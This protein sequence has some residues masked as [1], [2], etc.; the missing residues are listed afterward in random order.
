[1]GKGMRG[2]SFCTSQ[3]AS[4]ELYPCIV[5]VAAPHHYVLQ[6]QAALRSWALDPKLALQ[7]ESKGMAILQT[8]PLLPILLRHLH[9]VF[10][11]MS[12]RW[13]KYTIAYRNG[14]ALDP[15]SSPHLSTLKATPCTSVSEESFFG[16]LSDQ[17]K[18]MVP[19]AAPWRVNAT[20][21]SRANAS[22]DMPLLDKN[23]S[24]VI[25]RAA[26][27][28]E[29]HGK[30]VKNFRI[31]L[32]KRKQND[33]L[34][35]KRQKE[36]AKRAKQQAQAQTAHAR[37]ERAKAKQPRRAPKKR[38]RAPDTHKAHQAK[39]RVVATEAQA[40]VN[41]SAQPS[42]S[43]R[44]RAIPRRLLDGCFVRIRTNLS[45]SN[46]VLLN[47]LNGEAAPMTYCL[48]LCSAIVWPCPNPNPSIINLCS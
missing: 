11:V 20:A 7:F 29:M 31:Q 24:Q 21:I 15:T 42:R 10:R 45:K 25:H 44:A 2:R 40:I 43:H 26:R 6:F 1:M 19:T 8:H 46:I 28:E 13:Q 9:I 41:M 47:T 23:V 14:V 18:L 5:S 37:E 32:A 17:W 34:Q 12:E 30:C 33:I 22:V 39:R 3:H 48:P 27:V 38:W 16:A 4:R 36:E 35:A